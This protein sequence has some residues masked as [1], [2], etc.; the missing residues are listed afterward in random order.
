MLPT[1]CRSL[2]NKRCVF[3]LSQVAPLNAGAGNLFL[4]PWGFNSICFPPTLTSLTFRFILL[5]RVVM[6]RV[7]SAQADWT[8]THTSHKDTEQSTIEASITLDGVT[9]TASLI[10]WSPNEWPSV[11]LGIPV[12]VDKIL[13][14]SNKPAKSTSYLLSTTCFFLNLVM[15]NSI[16]NNICVHCCIVTCGSLLQR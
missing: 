5:V 4:A 6:Y 14:T 10:R 3:L 8:L 11:C 9:L 12:P 7:S 13:W 2:I 16:K 1:Y 15:K